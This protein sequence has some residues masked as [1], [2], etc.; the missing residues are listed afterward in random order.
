M[1]NFKRT[2]AISVWNK[3]LWHL[4]NVFR[5]CTVDVDSYNGRWALCGD[6]KRVFFINLNE[7]ELNHVRKPTKP[8]LFKT[9][10]GT[11]NKF[12]INKTINSIVRNNWNEND[13]KGFNIVMLSQQ[14]CSTTSAVQHF[15]FHNRTFATIAIG[16][17]Y[18]STFAMNYTLSDYTHSGSNKIWY[19]HTK[20]SVHIKI[21][22]IFCWKKIRRKQKTGNELKY[23]HDITRKH[24]TDQSDKCTHRIVANWPLEQRLFIDWINTA[25]IFMKLRIEWHNKI[26]STQAT[27]FSTENP[28]TSSKIKHFTIAANEFSCISF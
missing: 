10:T 15:P 13:K 14:S 1:H 3:N 16:S 4:L 8:P 24:P 7:V 22:V 9:H 23:T 2:H 20:K 17:A 25:L 12:A 27:R 6:W 21:Y 19:F 28:N 5:V 26:D 18:Q 11:Q